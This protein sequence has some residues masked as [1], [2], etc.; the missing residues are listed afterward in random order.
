MTSHTC[1]TPATHRNT[2]RNTPQHTATHCNTLQHTATHCNIL[3][4]TEP[5]EADEE[6]GTVRWVYNTAK[7]NSKRWETGENEVCVT[8]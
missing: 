1:N 7:A 2:Q 3:Q 4:H 8:E 6:V 5:D